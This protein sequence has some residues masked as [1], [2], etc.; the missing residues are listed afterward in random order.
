MQPGDLSGPDAGY[1]LRRMSEKRSS[2]AHALRYRAR[3]PPA[4]CSAIAARAEQRRD[5]VRVVNAQRAGELDCDRDNPERGVIVERSWELLAARV[6]VPG[7]V[8]Q[9]LGAD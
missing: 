7:H 3:S 9:R 1:A 8:E 5:V 6:A 2:T 4:I